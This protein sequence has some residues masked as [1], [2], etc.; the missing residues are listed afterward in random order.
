M[1]TS[2]MAKSWILLLLFP[3][4]GLPAQTNQT[5]PPPSKSAQREPNEWSLRGRL[6]VNPHDKETH[7]KLCSLLEKRKDF[8]SLA[9]ERWAWLEDNPGDS[10]ELISLIVEAQFRLTDPEYAI[11][12]TRRFLSNLGP[13]DDFL[14]WANNQLG[15]QLAARNRLSEAIPFLQAATKIKPDIEDFWADL[16]DA[17]VRTGQ[18]DS[19]I[20]ALKKAV[21]LYSASSDFHSRLGDALAA[22]GDLAG[23]ETEY[24]AA[25]NLDKNN[26]KRLAALARLQ[27]TRGELREAEEH[28]DRA[29]Q[30]DRFELYAYLLRARILQMR[31]QMSDAEAQ[32][33]KAESLLAE[34]EQK[35]KRVKSEMKSEG[36]SA[37][38]VIFVEDDPQEIVRIIKSLKEPLRPLDRRVLGL[39]YL[40]L[41]EKEEGTTELEKSFADS[42]LDIARSHFIVA[43]AFKKAGLYQRAVD[44]YRRAYE[45]DPENTTF[46]YEYETLRQL[47]GVK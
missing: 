19:G 15:K 41:E 47:N 3:M 46:R 21:D 28:L 18:T 12:A 20:R 33:Q 39:A 17:L 1:K 32:R 24:K 38:L 6:A 9:R 22:K 8:R 7:R 25:C 26:A 4:T 34:E 29:L 2:M 14:G 23:Q 45:M 40:E 43:E 44:H 13:A 11:A 37:P 30:A 27:I 16:G 35:E 42:E 5:K 31:G 36:L 10:G